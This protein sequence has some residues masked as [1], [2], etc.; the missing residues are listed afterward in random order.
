MCGPF[1]LVFKNGVSAPRI[2]SL[3][4]P[5]TFPLAGSGNIWTDLKPSWVVVDNISKSL[6]KAF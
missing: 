3:L 6:P 1:C 2:G 4:H 5:E